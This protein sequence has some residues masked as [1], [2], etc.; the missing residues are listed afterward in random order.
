[1]GQFQ[2]IQRGLVHVTVSNGTVTVK[3]S[4]NE[5]AAV[6]NAIVTISDETGVGSAEIIV[7]QSASA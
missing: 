4:A 6:R 1:M 5:A 7:T 3:V 2:L